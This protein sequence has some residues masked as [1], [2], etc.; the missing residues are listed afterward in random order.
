MA[1]VYTSDC[2]SLTD[3][4]FICYFAIGSHGSIFD[5]F[6]VEYLRNRYIQTRYIPEGKEWPPNQPKYYVNLAV[7]HY[8]DSQAQEQVIFSSQRCK[9][10]NLHEEE[11]L[12]S[13]TTNQLPNKFKVT[14]EIVDLFSTNPH[15]GETEADIWFKKHFN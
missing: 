3:Y 14:R 15:M 13:H 6:L 9:H 10:I 11:F 12:F 4:H 8:Q 7:I 2:C 1:T 5:T